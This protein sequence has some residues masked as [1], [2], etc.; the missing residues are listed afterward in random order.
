MSTPPDV[1]A[2]GAEAVKIYRSAV[3][4]GTAPRLAEMLALRTVPA[5]RTTD[6]YFKGR[7]N[8]VQ[9]FGEAG[10]R[11]VAEG[12]AKNGYNVKPGDVYNPTLASKPFD[13]D[14]VESPTR[15]GRDRTRQV[16]QAK[17]DRYYREKERRVKQGGVI[18]E[19][20][21]QRRQARLE[22]SDEGL[23]RR[24]KRESREAAIASL[25]E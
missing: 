3:R 25:K 9:Q 24:G 17:E 5:A 20:K 1:Q 6:D 16:Y 18:P 2:A 8:L 14:A 12:L 4:K 11:R 19:D 22:A 13:P 15:G 10:A 23:R 21:I 7:H